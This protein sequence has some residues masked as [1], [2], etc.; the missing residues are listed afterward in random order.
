FYWGSVLATHLFAWL[1]LVS[2]SFVLPRVF[3][4]KAGA[5]KR[6]TPTPWGWSKSRDR[7]TPRKLRLADLERN[8]MAW[9]ADRDRP[10][11]RWVWCF[12]ALTMLLWM[13]FELDPLGNLAAQT[14]FVAL[15]VIHVFFKILLSA[16]ASYGF[17]TG[18]QD[19]TL[20][21]LLLTP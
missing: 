12:P 10:R 9:L 19:G 8:P 20:D 2:S 15:A 17:A 13:V 14:G 1:W 11:R 6:I 21:L 7:M 16:D 18:R 4:E 5:D 3:L